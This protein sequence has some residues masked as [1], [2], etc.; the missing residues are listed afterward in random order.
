MT[1]IDPQCA[2]FLKHL[3]E[4]GFRAAHT[5]SI[6]ESRDALTAMVVGLTKSKTPIKKVED[7]LVPGPGG[8]IPVRI[9]WPRLPKE[10]ELMPG[11]CYIHGGGFYMGSIDTH[12]HVCRNIANMGDMVVASIDYRLA[13]E[14]KFPAA[15]DDCYAAVQWISDNAASLGIDPDRIAIAGDSAGGTLV[16]TTSMLARDRGG[17]K[18]AAQAPI[19]APLDIRDNPPYPSRI[20]L[21]TGEYFIHEKDLAYIARAY[22]NDPEAEAADWRVSPLCATDYSN[23]PRALVV[24]AELDPV[25]DENKIYADRLKEAGVPADYL[26]VPGA[27]HPFFI[28]DDMIYIGRKCQKDVAEWLGKTLRA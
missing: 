26:C 7:R 18:I 25:C 1:Y 8:N 5:I 28:L 14:N 23:L 2:A 10:G 22:L 27:V 24:T 3:N 19:Y 4:S 17:P 16:V 21:G 9:F 6:E 11:L 15:V 13:P 20:K 12:D